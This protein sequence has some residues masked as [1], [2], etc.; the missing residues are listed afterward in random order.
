MNSVRASSNCLRPYHP[1][2]L[3]IRF[4]STS[5]VHL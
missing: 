5:C 4:N 1:N 3:Q 2:Y